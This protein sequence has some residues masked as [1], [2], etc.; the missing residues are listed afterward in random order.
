[1]RSYVLVPSPLL[2]PATWDPV[3]AVLR[4]LGARAEVAV[5]DDVLAVADGLPDVV[6]V[7]HSNAGLRASWWASLLPAAATVYVDAALPPADAEDVPLAAPDFRDFLAGLVRGDGLLPPWTHWWESPHDLFPDASARAAVEAQQPRLPL[8][9][10]DDRVPVAPGWAGRDCAYLAFGDTYADE[11]AF[12]R[13]HGWPTATLAGG[14]LHQLHD[15]AGVATAIVA[16]VE[17][18]AAGA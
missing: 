1:M 10:F 15:P 11:V 12:A 14:H 17:E 9:W 6:L 13:A 8:V 2:G 4:D 5:V 3:A 18:L 7:P 16:L